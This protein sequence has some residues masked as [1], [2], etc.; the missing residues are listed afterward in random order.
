ME[1]LMR[2]VIRSANSRRLQRGQSLVEVSLSLT[3]LLMLVSGIVDLGRAF[4]TKVALDSMISEGAHWA[5][6]YPA[7]IPYA[8]NA[9]NATYVPVNCRGTNSVIGR[10]ILESNDLNRSLFVAMSVTP[11][12]AAAGD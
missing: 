3:I 11:V 9:T 4:M 2:P 6:A 8:Q 12:S 1:Q 10:M 5:A 7:C